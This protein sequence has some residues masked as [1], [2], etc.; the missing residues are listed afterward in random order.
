MQ[1][2]I[3]ELRHLT[4]AP[5][6]RSRR[7]SQQPPC[8]S[9]LALQVGRA[10]GVRFRRIS[11]TAENGIFIAGTAGRRISGLS[12]KGVQLDLVKR[13]EW[14]GGSQDFRPGVRGLVHSGR[15]APIW[16]EH[17]EHLVFNHVTVSEG[18]PIA[19]CC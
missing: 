5:P 4:I 17:A 19:G 6:W 12:F 8:L 11:A 14:P 1:S 9:A 3:S 7:R 16:A 15:T 13:T 2:S 18:P 10:A